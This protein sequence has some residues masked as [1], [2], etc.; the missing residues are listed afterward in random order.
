MSVP[1]EEPGVAVDSQHGVT[2]MVINSTV[3]CKELCRCVPYFKFICTEVTHLTV[4]VRGDVLKAA[5]QL[6]LLLMLNL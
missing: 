5:P 6:F 2:L 4:A 3:E 1:L